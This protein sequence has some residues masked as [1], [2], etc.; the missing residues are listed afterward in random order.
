MPHTSVWIHDSIFTPL[1]APAVPLHCSFIFGFPPRQPDCETGSH[2]CSPF[3]RWARRFCRAEIC[4]LIGVCWS[5]CAAWLQ[6]LSSVQV[7]C[8]HLL[9][10]LNLPGVNFQPPE[11]HLLSEFSHHQCPV[12][13]VPACRTHSSPSSP[14][15]E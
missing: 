2:F 14:L 4:L 11:H 13:P 3:I 10:C 8:V 7:K 9:T 1:V 6:Q 12:C 15:L 5:S